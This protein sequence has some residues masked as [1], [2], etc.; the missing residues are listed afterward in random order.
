MKEN[1]LQ[2]IARQSREKEVSEKHAK[3]IQ[4]WVK[5]YISQL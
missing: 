4:E 2:E 5:S 1:E 3:A